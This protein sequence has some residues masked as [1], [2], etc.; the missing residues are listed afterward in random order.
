M[1]KL[2]LLLLVL[3]SASAA[4]LYA[5]PSTQLAGLRLI[6]QYRQAARETAIE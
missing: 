3:L 4:I 1:K 5:F 6:E 2:L